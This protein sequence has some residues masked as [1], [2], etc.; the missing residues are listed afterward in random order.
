AL[1]LAVVGEALRVT[2]GL[3]FHT[4]IPGE[5]YRCGQPSERDIE[6]FVRD[7]G[8]RTVINLRGRLDGADWYEAEA[9]TCQRLGVSNQVFTMS[10]MRVPGR[11]EVRRLIEVLDH[12]E[13]PIVMHCR[14]G[15]DRTG[16]ATAIALLLR[17]EFTYEDAKSRLGIRWG[18]WSIGPADNLS[19][20]FD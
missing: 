8:V 17:P 4:V 10:A 14:Q 16:L 13:R 15:A 18:H 20:F 7:Y 11:H 3:N 12:A 19:R 6:S 5:L 1:A 2:V 9:R